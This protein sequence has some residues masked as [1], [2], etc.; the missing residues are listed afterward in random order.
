VNT[1][2]LPLAIQTGDSFHDQVDVVVLYW[3]G[4]MSGN[5]N[6]F[7]FSFYIFVVIRFVFIALPGK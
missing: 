2:A 4:V 6:G 7:D 3:G 5:G 1:G